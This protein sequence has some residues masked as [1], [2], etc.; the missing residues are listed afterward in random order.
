MKSFDW[1]YSHGVLH[2]TPDIQRAI[3]EVWRVL[4]PNGRTIIMLYHKHSFN[5]FVRIMTYMRLRV[6][7]KILSRVG[8]WKRDREP[9]ATNQMVGLRGNQNPQHGKF[10]IRIS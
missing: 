9:L 6:L 5:Y 3:D 8:N 4:K 10:I 2:H 1:F 7:L